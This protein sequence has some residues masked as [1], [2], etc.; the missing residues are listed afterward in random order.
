MILVTKAVAA[1]IWDKGNF[2]TCQRPAHM[3][4]G[5]L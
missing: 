5:L 4:R 3:A 2:M 1:I